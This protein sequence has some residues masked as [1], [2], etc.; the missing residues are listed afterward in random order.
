MNNIFLTDSKFG[1][2]VLKNIYEFFEEPR[3]FSVSN[4][5]GGLFIVYWIGDEDDYDKWYV[6]PIS[7]ERLE[8]LERK[9][10]DLYSSLV[11]QEQKTFYQVN[12]PYDDESEEYIKLSS[13][14]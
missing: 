10:I 11:Y 3:F 8:L 7:P 12:I 1:T 4:E 2:L 5:V 6:I 14:S 13:D 9:R